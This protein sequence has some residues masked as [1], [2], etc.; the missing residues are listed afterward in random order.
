MNSQFTVSNKCDP[1]NLCKQNA[2]TD[3]LEWSEL[4]PSLNR[5]VKTFS[6]MTIS[7]MTWKM[8]L[9]YRSESGL[10]GNLAD[11][12]LVFRRSWVSQTNIIL[13][14]CLLVK[15]KVR[16]CSCHMWSRCTTKYILFYFK[17]FP[18]SSDT[19]LGIQMTFDVISAAVSL[20]QNCN[21]KFLRA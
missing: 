15:P 10:T 19:M 4:K 2:S 12:S 9:I 17:S 20:R 16:S 3:K 5:L 14:V 1:L 6:W 11:L 7:L 21:R 18:T 8:N 13:R